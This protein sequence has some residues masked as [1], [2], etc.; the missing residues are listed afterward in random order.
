VTG[1]VTSSIF[2]F[3]SSYKQKTQQL[4]ER[5][6]TYHLEKLSIA[7]IQNEQVGRAILVNNGGHVHAKEKGAMKRLM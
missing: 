4:T 7:F 2:V 6:K 3:K 1:H 5:E